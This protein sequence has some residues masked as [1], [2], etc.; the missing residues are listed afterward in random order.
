MT[1]ALRHTI[2]FIQKGLPYSLTKKKTI[3]L[4]LMEAPHIAKTP[5]RLAR[6]A[7]AANISAHRWVIGIARKKGIKPD[8]MSRALLKLVSNKEIRRLCVKA[9]VEKQKRGI[10]VIPRGYENQI[11]GVMSAIKRKY[12]FSSWEQTAEAIEKNPKIGGEFARLLARV[13]HPGPDIERSGEKELIYSLLGGKKKPII[14][15]VGIG[16]GISTEALALFLKKKGLAPNIIGIDIFP[17]PETIARSKKGGFRFVEKDVIR[18]PLIAN[19]A[20]LADVVRAGRVLR[21]ITRNEQRKAIQ[22]MLAALKTGGYLYIPH[23][24]YR[25]TSEH[26]V[27]I[28]KQ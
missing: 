14:I 1:Q 10:T 8:P 21:Y 2:S 9:L 5:T 4:A 25:K 19:G 11:E 23:D 28:I 26:T 12:C 18:E 15:D 3:N 22:N 6:H 20:A 27:E 7:L 24:I 16:H 17:Y 13:S